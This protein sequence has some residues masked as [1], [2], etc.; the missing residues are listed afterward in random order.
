MEITKIIGIGIIGT[1]AAVTVKNYR[2][3]LGVIIA[4]ATGAV[5]LWNILP[6]LQD[7]IFLL[8]E[9]CRQQ[10]ITEA[11]F[12]IIIKVIGIA[13]ITQFSAELAKDAG[14]G[15]IAKK[16]EFAGKVSVLCVMMPT[17]KDLLD[18]ITSTLMSF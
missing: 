15:A 2:S 13:Y 4:F 10:E 9:I 16:V 12:E 11:Y 5:I 3:D 7:T 17:I 14:E 8:S 18:I 6:R 1:I